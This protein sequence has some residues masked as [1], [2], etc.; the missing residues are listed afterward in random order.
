MV[1]LSVALLLLKADATVTIIH[2][3]AHDS[4]SIIREADIVITAAGQAKMIEGDWIK[5]G[6]A[7]IDVGTNAIDDP[8]RISGYRVVGDVDFEEASKVAGWLTPFPGGVG[9]MTV[10]MLIKNTL[11]G[12]KRKITQ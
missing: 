9:P 12:V 4:K 6:A 5:S 3:H 8:S 2:S 7:V 10:A 1:E 11:D